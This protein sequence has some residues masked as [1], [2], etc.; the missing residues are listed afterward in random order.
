MKTFEEKIAKFLSAEDMCRFIVLPVGNVNKLVLEDCN[1]IKVEAFEE[2]FLELKTPRGYVRQEVTKDTVSEYAF[3]YNSRGKAAV[4]VG[5][6]QEYLGFAES[7]AKMLAIAVKE[8]KA[9][10]FIYNSATMER[11]FMLGVA[12]TKKIQ[13]ISELFKTLSNM[14][15]CEGEPI[16][17]DETDE[18]NAVTKPMEADCDGKE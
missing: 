15:F 17:F 6:T 18:E 9:V 1:R 8:D 13:N 11:V 4:S 7:K 16:A 2:M 10:I 12:G 14:G 3:Y 5:G